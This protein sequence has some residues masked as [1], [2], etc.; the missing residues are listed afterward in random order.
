MISITKTNNIENNLDKQNL[1]LSILHQNYTKWNDASKQS[2]KNQSWRNNFNLIQPDK[3]L[4]KGNNNE[5][6][7]IPN[8]FP[9]IINDIKNFNEWKK[10]FNNT[11]NNN[12]LIKMN[13]TFKY[14]DNNAE[15]WNTAYNFYNSLYKNINSIQHDAI[16]TKK[17]NNQI[18]SIQASHHDLNSTI[19]KRDNDGSFHT[20]KIFLN[21][22]NEINNSIH[23]N[24]KKIITSG[25]ITSNNFIGNLQGNIPIHTDIISNNNQYILFSNIKNGNTIP[26]TG[27]IAYNPSTDTLYCTN[28]NAININYK[29]NID[30]PFNNIPHDKIIIKG[31]NK[32]EFTF[33][34]NNSNKWNETYDTISNATSID[35]PNTIVKRNNHNNIYTSKFI[36]LNKTN[37]EQNEYI[38]NMQNGIISNYINIFDN[39]EYKHAWTI[40]SSINIINNYQQINRLY[41][42]QQKQNNKNTSSIWISSSAYTKNIHVKQI[43]CSPKQDV[44]INNLS[45]LNGYIVSSSGEFYNIFNINGNSPPNIPQ[46]CESIPTFILSNTQKDKTVLGVIDEYDKKISCYFNDGTYNKFRK[47]SWSVFNY[48]TNGNYPD[49]DRFK[50]N[51]SGHGAVMV[52]NFNGNIQ[53]GDYITTWNQGIGMKQNDNTL[54]NYTVAKSLQNENF[55]NDFEII[56]YKNVEYKFK[57][58]GCTY[59]C[60]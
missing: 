9:T 29:N 33:T 7:S 54:H 25:T 60:G 43:K 11:P 42:N 17:S 39:I 31:K 47:F 56:T 55:S 40:F 27:F 20:N 57:L 15:Q 35:T 18:S 45:N 12:I 10:S 1:L 58:I 30:N 36:S 41:F 26:N 4:I 28:I 13:D 59:L 34:D 49:K 24:T 51:T 52:S 3:I 22:I 14:I 46:I 21:H 6:K 37:K 8:Q 19:V 16:L 38:N 48:A 5:F 32:N 2:T 44:I 23:I 50:I 53:N